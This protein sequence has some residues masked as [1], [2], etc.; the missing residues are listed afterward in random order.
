MPSYATG[1][2][3]MFAGNVLE[4]FRMDCFRQTIILPGRMVCLLHVHLT[5][6]SFIE[7]FVQK[8]NYSGSRQLKEPV[9]SDSLEPVDT[10]SPRNQ[11]Q[12]MRC[13]KRYKKI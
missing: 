1:T 2:L 13:L 12:N 6:E 7:A 11:R 9:L 8:F 10:P 4:L 5:L 3:S